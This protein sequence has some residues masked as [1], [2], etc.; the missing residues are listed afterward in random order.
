MKYESK[1]ESQSL[2]SGKKETYN[3]G[4]LHDKVNMFKKQHIISMFHII[5]I[6]HIYV[7]SI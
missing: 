7:S 3:E 1:F 4:T 6:F 5:S 2:E